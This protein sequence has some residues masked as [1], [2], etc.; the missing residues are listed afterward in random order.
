MTQKISG[1]SNQKFWLNGKRP[2]FFSSEGARRV[3]RGGGNFSART[4]YLH[5]RLSERD[6]TKTTTHIGG[7]ELCVPAVASVMSHLIEHVLSEANLAWVGSN[8]QQEQIHP[9]EKVPHGLRTNNFLRIKIKHI[10]R[11]F[12]AVLNVV[13]KLIGL[14]NDYRSV[15]Q[16]HRQASFAL[17]ISIRAITCMLCARGYSF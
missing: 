9:A 12:R 4:C 1:I 11:F 15:V 6:E 16:I 2:C 14:I 3:S 7:E 10:T 17:N 8:L 13:S 5:G